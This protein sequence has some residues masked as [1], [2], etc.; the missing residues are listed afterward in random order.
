MKFNP[1]L[2]TGLKDQQVTKKAENG[3]EII[4]LNIK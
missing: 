3:M 1:Y 2:K 4:M